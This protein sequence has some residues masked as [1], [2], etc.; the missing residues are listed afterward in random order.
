MYT[1]EII[2]LLNYLLR[3]FFQNDSTQLSYTSQYTRLIQNNVL[4]T[5]KT[6][7][8]SARLFSVMILQ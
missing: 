7:Y 2:F 3:E 8:A 6:K 5:G 1:F 4:Y